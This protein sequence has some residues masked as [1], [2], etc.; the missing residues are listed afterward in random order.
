MKGKWGNRIN[1]E[2][3]FP[4]FQENL[5]TSDRACPVS[6]LD[7]VKHHQH[8]ISHSTFLPEILTHF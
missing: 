5:E 8:V 7:F 3:I 4:V 2:E 6:W 1:S